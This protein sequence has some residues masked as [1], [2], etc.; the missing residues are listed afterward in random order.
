MQ[1]LGSGQ[2]FGSVN[3]G[4]EVVEGVEE[5]LYLG[6]KQTSDG[7]CWPDITRRI[8]LASAVMSSLR[9]VWNNGQLS[10]DTKIHVY[11]ALVLSVLLYGSETWTLLADDARKLEAFHM[12]C[13]RQ[14]L[15]VSWRDHITNAEITDR[16]RLTSLK[17]Q[18]SSRRAS[19]FGHIA[20]LD[21]TV[22]AHLALWLQTDITIGRKPDASWRRTPGRPRKTWISQIQEDVHMSARSY[23]DA[24]TR[25]GHGRMTQR[26]FMTTRS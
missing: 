23:W 22:P 21:T 17:E 13:Q 16:T 2:P 5:F 25:R 19:L 11:R 24:S 15:R 6:N 12:R 14:L 9:R 10:T 18:L 20:R 7:S 26:S 4:D 1:N 8:G 3:V